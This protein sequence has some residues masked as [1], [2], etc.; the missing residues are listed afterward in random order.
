MS[1]HVVHITLT[2]QSLTAQLLGAP[3]YDHKQD[4]HRAVALALAER[5]G[6]IDQLRDTE[7]ALRINAEVQGAYARAVCDERAAAIARAET[8]EA[9]VVELREALRLLYDAVEYDRDPR[10]GTSPSVT[11]SSPLGIA[12]RALTKTPADMGKRLYQMEAKLRT[13]TDALATHGYLDSSPELGDNL[14]ANI[15]KMGAEL[16]RLRVVEI[17]ATRDGKTIVRQQATIEGKTSEIIALRAR[18]AELETWK[19]EQLAVEASWDVQE[20]G[21]LLDIRPGI[22]IRPRIAAGIRLLRAQNTD[23][24]NR[25]IVGSIAYHELDEKYQAAKAA[26]AKAMDTLDSYGRTHPDLPSAVAALMQ[27]YTDAH[28]TL[29]WLET[30]CDVRIQPKRGGLFLN[31]PNLVELCRAE[32]QHYSTLKK[33]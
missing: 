33:S 31:C 20:V 4:A 32:R 24:E 2:V 11:P 14:V 7:K 3:A 19:R 16:A 12:R 29:S 10:E 8:A 25:E 28:L 13:A 30:A 23:L 1:Q 6:V 22:N 21:R 9:L 17:E 18:V 26:I 5:D 27:H 15:A